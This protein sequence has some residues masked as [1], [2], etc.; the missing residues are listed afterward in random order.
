MSSLANLSENDKKKIQKRNKGNKKTMEKR[1][2]GYI[3]TLTAKEPVTATDVN[4]HLRVKF[5]DY[6]RLP[7]SRL[8]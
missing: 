5:Y 7:E 1:I 2:M 3:D 6:G 4:S 8:K